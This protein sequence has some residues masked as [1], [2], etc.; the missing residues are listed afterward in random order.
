VRAEIDAREGHIAVHPR[1]L[2][3]PSEV[4][5]PTASARQLLLIDAN[6]AAAGVI[7]CGAL[8]G[9][10]ADLPLL[11]NWG[12]DFVTMKPVT[13]LALLLVAL[14]LSPLLS[15]AK[16]WRVAIGVIVAILGASSLIHELGGLD[17]GPESWLAPPGAVPGP[18][19]TNF[20]MSPATALAVLLAGAVIALLPFWR[21]ADAVRFL[22]AGMG[23]LGATALLGYVLGVD[24]LYSFPPYN[25][26][27]LPTA[28]ASIAI[29]V[30]AVTYVS[31][32]SPARRGDW[33]LFL[34][35]FF[36]PLLIFSLFTWWSWRNVEAQ[37]R[38]DADR[39]VALASQYAQRVFEIRITHSV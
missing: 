19:S 20:I 38:A 33:R 24:A 28:V 30:A 17:L 15:V 29:S 4:M 32:S 6:L 36:T 2:V 5:V 26:V 10:L 8:V 14:C 23:V 31:Q 22:A 39:T 16:R 18:N 34:A 7:S 27:A 9:W 37:A 13:A 25:S 21:L 35:Q 1:S 3:P 12:P 11:T